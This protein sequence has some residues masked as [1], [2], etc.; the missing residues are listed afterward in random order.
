MRRKLGLGGYAMRPILLCWIAVSGLALAAPR[1]AMAAPGADREQAANAV[2]ERVRSDPARLRVFLKAMPKGGDL[3]NHVDG[4]PYAEAYLGWAG[5]KGLCVDRVALSIVDPPCA[6]PDRVAAAG[7]ETAD[8]V[9]EQRLID[10][11]S[12]RGWSEGVGRETGSG[13]DRMFGAFGRFLAVAR[14]SPGLS[15]AEVRRI[16]ALDHVSY[17]EL[18]YNPLQINRFAL[19]TRDPDWKDDDL[20]GAFAR[21]QPLLPELL[22]WAQRET[23]ATDTAARNALGCGTASPEPGC[24]VSYRYIGYGLRLLPPAQLFRQLVVLF[25]LA[26]TDPRYVGVNLV[27]PEDDPLAIAHYRLTMRMVAF[28]AT[29][30]PRVHRSWHAGEL[31]LGMVPPEA[32]ADHIAQAVGEGRAERIGHGTD[33][34]YE[35]DAAATLAEMARRH[36]D[37]EI[38]LS[39][40]DVILGVKGAAHP[41]RLYV[42]AGVPVTLSTDD[43]GVLRTDMTEQY[44]RAAIDHRMGYRDLKRMA[45]ASLEYAFIPGESLWAGRET[46]HP[47]G[48]CAALASAECAALAVSSPKAALQR[49]LERQFETFETTIARQRF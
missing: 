24:A 35:S 20:E 30:Y 18:M 22:A 14:L 6:A 49:D 45:R 39:S 41:L 21:M 8:P 23:D 9:L 10:A 31:T 1:A 5:R 19:T 38:N 12:V 43:E 11:L 34:A 16:A 48:A 26:D 37:V 42:A 47:I 29:H 40:N 27:Q 25:A 36:V 32:L 13:H 15:V 33:I 4:S 2:F 3:H 28:L 44:M 17:L 46:G 7:L